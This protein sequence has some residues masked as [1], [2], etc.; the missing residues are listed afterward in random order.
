MYEDGRDV[1]NAEAGDQAG[2]VALEEVAATV[3]LSRRAGKLYPPQ[4]APVQPV[5]FAGD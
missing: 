2:V 4:N 3:G 5:C 1:V